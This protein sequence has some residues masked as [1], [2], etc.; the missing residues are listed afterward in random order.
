[1]TIPKGS[2]ACVIT[3]FVTAIFVACVTVSL[4]N[5]SDGGVVALSL[6]PLN[7][8]FSLMF[9]MDINT[10]TALSIPGTFATAYGFV[11][12][13]SRVIISMARSGLFPPVLM[14]TWGSYE[15]P[16]VA[17]LVGSILGYSL[18]IAAYFV[19]TILLY[20]YNICIM[21]A[22]MAYTSQC[23]GYIVFKTQ[24]VSQ[25]RKFVSPFGIPGAVFS[26]FVFTL[27]FI[28]VAGFQNDH[29]IAFGSFLGIFVLSTVYYYLYAK[30]R[31]HFSPE[32]KHIYYKI[33][34]VMCK[35]RTVHTTTNF[36]ILI[37]FLFIRLTYSFIY[38]CLPSFFFF[39]LS[40]LVNERARLLA[41][42]GKQK[43][44]MEV[45]KEAFHEYGMKKPTVYP[46]LIK[47]H[48]Q[49]LH[50]IKVKKYF[51]EESKPI[52][53][54]V[55]SSKSNKSTHMNQIRTTQ[56]PVPQLPESLD[57]EKGKMTEQGSNENSVMIFDLETSC[58]EEQIPEGQMETKPMR[59]SFNNH[60]SFVFPTNETEGHK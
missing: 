43:T 37:H 7:P 16:Y 47:E 3:L 45:L 38:M 26:A 30:K 57:E 4:P 56:L 23:L 10:A 49:K 53:Y 17:V 50:V 42:K 20:L 33:H 58:L 54:H 39:L 31:Q 35:Y 52:R 19:P 41:T 22:F 1:M 32:E 28:G 25:E 34:I 24:F 51:D 5:G 27:A 13:Y 44:Y 21:S 29:Q 12:A 48:S 60:V 46:K 9:N 36:E 6:T 15:T 2:I 14:F 55:G 59:R 8:G 11:F 40:T 18:C